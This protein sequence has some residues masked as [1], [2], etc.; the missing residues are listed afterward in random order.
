MEPALELILGNKF[1]EAVQV[2][3]DMLHNIYVL[4]SNFSYKKIDT[5]KQILCN[6]SKIK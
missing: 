4:V 6:M 5:E 3:S 1:L 2:H